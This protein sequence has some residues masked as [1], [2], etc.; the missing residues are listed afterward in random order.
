MRLD[1]FL[2]G[3]LLGSLVGM[4][5]GPIGAL[6]TRKVLT[7]GPRYGIMYGF[8]SAL[9]DLLYAAAAGWGL[10]FVAHFLMT[11]RS[12]FKLIGGILVI[13]LGVR[14]FFAKPVSAP[15][16]LPAT[17][18]LPRWCGTGYLGAFFTAFV[19]AIANPVTFFSFL[20]LITFL[21]L[22]GLAKNSLP[23][24]LE[25]VFGVFLGSFAWW[26][27]LSYGIQFLKRKF[28]PEKINLLWLNRIFGFVIC[29]LG[30]VIL[31][32]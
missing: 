15:Q 8:G 17:K 6:A 4:P 24:I 30:I 22:E 9:A 19:L 26:F 31:V 13:L 29:L 18:L 28:N 32:R 20:G 27:L 23:A 21:G 7:D 5:L 16:A 25:L 2:K 10:T 1:L 11:Y 14:I 12:Q 3:I